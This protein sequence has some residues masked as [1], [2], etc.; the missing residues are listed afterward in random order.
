MKIYFQCIGNKLHEIACEA[1]DEVVIVAPF[2]KANVIVRLLEAVSKSVSIICI[3]RWRPDEIVQ[4]LNDLEI[5]DYINKRDNAIMLLHGNLH[6]K[7]YRFDDTVLIGSANLTGKALGWTSNPNLELLS[8]H[9]KEFTETR[10][11]EESLCELS[12]K[13]NGYIYDYMLELVKRY[14]EKQQ[15]DCK[16]ENIS[17]EIIDEL[18]MQQNATVWIP[19]LRKPE[20]LFKV[21][22]K[23]TNYIIETTVQSACFDL[24]SLQIPPGLDEDGFNVYVKSMLLQQ[25]IIKKMDSYLTEPQRFGA[26]REYLREYYFKNEID[27]DPTMSWQVIMRWL[28]YYL[29]DIYGL[30][31]PNHSEVIYKKYQ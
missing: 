25:P 23:D 10:F 8:E 16:S 31:V 26:M 28:L 20:L 11:F 27:L 9:P 13:V 5:W 15:I 1:K 6:A 17:Y 12:T 22:S 18:P 4:G 30:N 7:Y 3:T 24:L 14:K 19:K 21:Y 29:P 2:M